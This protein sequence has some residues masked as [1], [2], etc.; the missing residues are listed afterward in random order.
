[1]LGVSKNFLKVVASTILELVCKVVICNSS[2]VILQINL[3]FVVVPTLFYK[4]I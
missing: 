4:K 2:Y 3:N 1:M